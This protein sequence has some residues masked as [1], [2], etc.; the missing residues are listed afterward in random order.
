MTSTCAIVV[1][2]YRQPTASEWLSIDC[3]KAVLPA[4]P[5]FLLKPKGLELSIDGFSNCSM[6]DGWFASTK[7]YGLL[8]ASPVLYEQFT[9]FDY[10]LIYQL[11]CLVF[12]NDLQAWCAKGYDLCSSACLSSLGPWMTEPFVSFGGLSLRNV[13][14]CLRVLHRVQANDPGL[15]RHARELL[16][17]GQEDVWWGCRAPAFD[18][19]FRVLPVEESFSFAFDGN[20]LPYAA[21]CPSLPPFACHAWLSVGRLLFYRRFLPF[22]GFTALPKVSRVLLMLLCRSLAFRLRLLAAKTRRL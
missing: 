15:V 7:T 1:P 16:V 19:T 20:P 8:M 14:S 3:L 2:T 9:A 21:H 22:S 12:R 13:R 18:P 17:F 6:D 10:I 5:T 11:D 4:F